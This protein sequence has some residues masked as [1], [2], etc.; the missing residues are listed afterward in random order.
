MAEVPDTYQSLLEKTLG[1]FQ[2]V[3]REVDCDY[4]LKCDDDTFVLVARLLKVP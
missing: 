3:E 1:I 2:Y 4:V